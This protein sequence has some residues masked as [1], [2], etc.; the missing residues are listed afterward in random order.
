MT[1]A[2]IIQPET[3][4]KLQ[5]GDKMINIYLAQAV[6]KYGIWMKDFQAADEVEVFLVKSVRTAKQNKVFAR[7]E[8]I[9]DGRCRT[10]EVVKVFKVG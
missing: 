6:K 8:I 1:T 9:M 10:L 2:Q 4:I 7:I 5:P 3:A